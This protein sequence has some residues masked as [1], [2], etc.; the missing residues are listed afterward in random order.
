MSGSLLGIH[1]LYRDRD[2]RGGAVKQ[3]ERALLSRVMYP[4]DH[5]IW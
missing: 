2:V 5:M 4:S 1:E 3:T